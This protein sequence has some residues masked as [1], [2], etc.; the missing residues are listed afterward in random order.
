MLDVLGAAL[1]D[2]DSEG[3][4]ELLGATLVDGESEGDSESITE[5]H[6]AGRV[7]TVASSHVG[8]T[9]L[10]QLSIPRGISPL[11]PLKALK[12]AL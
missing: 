4:S 5:E 11:V 2:G 7:A 9:A 6:S 10:Q 8:V 3:H 1:V 12:Q